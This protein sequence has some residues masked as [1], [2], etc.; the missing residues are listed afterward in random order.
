MI[1]ARVGS[2]ASRAKTGTRYLHM[3]YATDCPRL[4]SSQQVADVLHPE[5][6]TVYP[7]CGLGRM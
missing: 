1:L 6:D 7:L 2:W 4:L 5:A 3:G